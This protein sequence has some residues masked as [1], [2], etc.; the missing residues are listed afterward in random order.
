M[1]GGGLQQALDLV[2]V[3]DDA[4]WAERHLGRLEATGRILLEQFLQVEEAEEGADLAGGVGDS[5]C[6]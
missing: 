6:A 3:E 5:P 4:G 1:L 2:W